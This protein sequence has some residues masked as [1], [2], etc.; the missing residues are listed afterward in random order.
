MGNGLIPVVELSGIDEMFQGPYL[1][2]YAAGNPARHLREPHTIRPSERIPVPWKSVDGLV[3][4]KKIDGFGS[5]VRSCVAL[6]LLEMG[7]WFYIKKGV[8]DL[9]ITG[10]DG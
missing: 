1:I 10:R 8:C 7:P 3:Q 9:G 2:K 5:K 6:G 4:L